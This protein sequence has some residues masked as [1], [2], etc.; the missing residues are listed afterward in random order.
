[1]CYK[2]VND[3]TDVQKVLLARH[4]RGH[5]DPSEA[6]RFK[7]DFRDCFDRKPIPRGIEEHLREDAEKYSE[8]NYEQA[9]ECYLLIKDYKKCE[10]VLDE[11]AKAYGASSHVIKLYKELDE[12]SYKR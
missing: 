2:E 9:Y 8:V 11:Q 10:E 7:R 3:S 1:M 6:R 4:E 12:V 5:K